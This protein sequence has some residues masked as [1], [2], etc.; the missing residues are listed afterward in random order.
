M[1]K[2]TEIVCEYQP[3]IDTPVAPASMYQQSCSNDATTVN[4]W[5][6]TWIR[7][8]RV[9]H[10]KFG[11]FSEHGLGQLWGKHLN[12]PGI[13]IGSG[14]HL[15]ENA[16]VLKDNPGIPVFSCL[17]NFHFLEDLGVN[18]DYYV[19]LDA[20]PVTIEEVYEGGSKS[21]DEYWAMTK[22]RKLLCYVATDP[23]LLELWKGEI[24]FFNCPVPDTSI[25]DEIDK[26]EKFHTAVSSGGNVLG[27]AT[28]IAK[29]IMG[30]NPLA[31]LG[32]SFS[33]DYKTNFHGWTSKYD[34]KLG[35]YVRATDVYGNSVK[36]WQS[37]LN[38]AQWF[39][40]LAETVPGFYINCTEGGIFGAYNGGNIRSVRQMDLKD[41]F[42]MQT[43]CY[44]TKLQCE[45]PAT[46]ERKIVF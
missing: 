18:V 25:L 39:N 42:R 23:R 38:F 14:P 3:Y 2:T 31:F 17:H 11:S 10:K 32:A 6:E 16:H 7:N 35:H 20:G 37:Y 30:C 36:T 8:A 45:N 22:N 44:E 13:V 5:R 29:A 28:Y 34:G 27:A 1:A 9:N 43:I 15:K 4:V 40:W 19:S 33:F 26:L 46:D 21:P 12:K 41:F 24:Y